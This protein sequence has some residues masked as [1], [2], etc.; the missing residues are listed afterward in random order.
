MSIILLIGGLVLFVGLVVVHEFGHFLAAKRAGVHVEEFGI[1]FPPRLWSRRTREGWTLSINLLPIGGFVR[2]KGEHDADRSPGSFGA[3]RLRSKVAIML[4][5]VVMNLITAFVLLTLLAVVGVPKL[6]DNQFSITRDEHISNQTLLIGYIEPGSPADK[7]GLQL[8]DQIDAVGRKPADCADTAAC[9]NKAEAEHV[10]TPEELKTI[11]RQNAGQRVEIFIERNGQPKTIT[12]QLRSAIEADQGYLGI[13]PTSYII[14]RYTWSA[15]L[16]AGG[17]IG[18]VTGLTFKGLGNALAGLFQG[19]TA[20]ASA[21]VAGP[22]GIFV[23]LKDG[24]FLG[25]QFVLLIIAIISLTLAIM[26]VLPI[27]ALDGGRLFVTLLFRWLKRPLHKHTEEL[28]H[29]IGFVSLL[30]LFVLITVV[31]VRRFF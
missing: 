26:N 17:L 4:A 20:K 29:G 5:G 19:N 21:Q 7:A 13:A 23:L 24:S 9:V 1:G 2:L 15:P 25:Y 12:V 28:I 30:A 8:R 27:P 22:V 6:I 11:T 14:T 10:T 18:Q 3:A 16:E 31:D